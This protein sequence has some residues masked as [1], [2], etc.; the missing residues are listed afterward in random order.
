MDGVLL[1]EQQPQLA[2]HHSSQVHNLLLTTA[3]R[4]QLEMNVV[5]LAEQA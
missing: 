5:L 3:Q 4:C 1:A 2:A